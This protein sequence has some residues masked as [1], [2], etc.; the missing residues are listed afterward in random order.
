VPVRALFEA[1]EPMALPRCE[2]GMGSVEGR[3]GALLVQQREFLGDVDL[4]AAA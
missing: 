3:S 4:A 1:V 2:V